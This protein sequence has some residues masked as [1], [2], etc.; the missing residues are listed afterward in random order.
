MKKSR[1]KL[2]Q[3]GFTLTETL[4]AILILAFSS[5]A[6]LF[7]IRGVL[8]IYNKLT[9]EAKIH[10]ELILFRETLKESLGDI[11]IPFWETEPD[12]ALSQ[13]NGI[14]SLPYYKGDK[15]AVLKLGFTQNGFSI[16]TPQGQTVIFPHITNVNIIPFKIDNMT[17]GLSIILHM[18][19]EELNFIL[20]FGGWPLIKEEKH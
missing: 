17:T 19:D 8:T 10:A 1:K 7:G 6:V 4:T 5:S 16:F 15:G 13:E 9:E 12:I 11:I 20:P 3:E 18:K 14:L 2:R